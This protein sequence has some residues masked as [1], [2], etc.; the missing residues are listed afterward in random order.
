MNIYLPIAEMSV[1][2]FLLL[3]LGGAAG[4]LSGLFGV[5]GG[6]LMTPLLMFIG[7]PPAVSVA[8][9][10]NQI[11]ASSVSGFAAHWQ[12]DNVDFKMGSFLLCGGFIGSIL[13]VALFRWL[14]QLGHIDL[15]I[16][17]I[18]VVFLGAIGAMMA[19]ESFR[20]ILGISKKSGPHDSVPFGRKLPFKIEFPKSKLTVSALM[21]IAIGLMIGILMSLMGVGGGFFLIPAMI[22]L[23]G[24]PTNLVIG[25]ALFQ[26][27]FVTANVTILH[28]ATTQTVDV[29]LALVL[30]TGSVFGAQVGSRISTKCPPEYLRAMLAVLALGIAIKLAF[31]LFTPPA[32]TFSVSVLND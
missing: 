29:I 7:V 23:L 18:Y 24:M 12:R 32:D 31:G 4:I 6:F 5:G 16:S 10:A 26:T 20:S 21:P 27:I 13:G 8:T 2:I 14:K 19:G 11:V 9:V 25:T 17:V 30:L 28:A 3:G 1:N 22:Y 15:I